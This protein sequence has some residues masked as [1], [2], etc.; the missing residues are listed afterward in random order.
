MKVVCHT[1]AI[2]DETGEKVMQFT[3]HKLYDASLSYDPKGWIVEDDNGKEETFFNLDIMF[4]N[5]LNKKMRQII[6]RGKSVETGEWVYGSLV[7]NMWTYSEHSKYP[8]GE[9]VCEIIT[10]NYEGDCWEDAVCDD[11][12]IVNVIPES[13]GQLLT[14][15]LLPNFYEGDIVGSYGNL[16]QEIDPDTIMEVTW[17]NREEVDATCGLIGN[18]F[19][20]PELL[21]P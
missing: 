20:N 17:D 7:N 8:K 15:K 11:K 1:E 2:D 6:F 14:H 12:C 9:K 3:K 4:K 13:V 10:G 18:R 21:K 5:F 19:D 16:E